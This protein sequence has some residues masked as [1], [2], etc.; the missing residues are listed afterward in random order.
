M[1][2]AVE[3]VAIAA[4]SASAGTSARHQDRQ[5][6]TDRFAIYQS[7]IRAWKA[8]DI[9]GVL[10]HMSDDI[11]WHYA[12][13]ISP[14]LIGK[15]PAR[16]F[17][18]DFAARIGEVRWRVFDYAQSGD[19]LFVEGV[20]EYIATNGAR[21]ATPYAG[22]LDF[23]GNLICGWRDYFDAAG[24]AAMQA[25]AKALPQVELLIARPAVN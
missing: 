19:R 21:I 12:A 22:V 15:G 8:K 3:L 25:G 4:T 11:V 13:A 24:P 20:D 17:M 7:V 1:L 9:E 18:Q 16:Q 6:M 5:P 14:P 10:A 23:R 2:G